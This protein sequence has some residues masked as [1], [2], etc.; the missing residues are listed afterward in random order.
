MNEWGLWFRAP[1]RT[2]SLHSLINYF[3]IFYAAVRTHASPIRAYSGAWHLIK[4]KVW[5]DNIIL[6][7]WTPQCFGFSNL[8]I[9]EVSSLLFCF[10]HEPQLTIQIKI[11]LE[12]NFP[13]PLNKQIADPENKHLI[14]EDVVGSCL[15]YVLG[16]MEKL[17]CGKLESSLWL[18][19]C[20][21]S[22]VSKKHE[23]LCTSGFSIDCEILSLIIFSFFV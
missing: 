1:V 21:F 8:N 15:C 23:E 17:Q 3:I 2:G 19:R 18:I 5:C 6:T 4:L 22:F 13:N 16:R 11:L 10:L 7:K 12:T 9:P 14:C 20:A